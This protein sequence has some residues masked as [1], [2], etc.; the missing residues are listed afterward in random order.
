MYLLF[1][2]KAPV[3]IEPNKIGKETQEMVEAEVRRVNKK[4][5]EKGFEHAV[6]DEVANVVTSTTV[7]DSTAIRERDSVIALLGIERKQLREWKQYNVTWRDSV[8]VAIRNDSGFRYVD[9]WADIQYVRPK[10]T[11]SNGHFNFRY[12]AELNHAEYWKRGWFLGKK[13]HYID[14]WVADKRAT[15]NGVKRLK[16]EVEEPKF[17]MDMGAKTLYNGVD[18][19]IYMG[20]EVGIDI[21]KVTIQGSYM[22]SPVDGKWYP[23]VSGKYKV[24][25]F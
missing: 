2:Y 20:G 15:V 17:G 18:R 7:L 21:G 12:N 6:I 1:F 8:L 9:K 22:Y 10:D 25:E 4:I 24:L 11:I 3:V 5:D 16:F 14:F 23:F 19:R 13:K